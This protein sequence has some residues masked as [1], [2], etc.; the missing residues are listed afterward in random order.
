MSLIPPFFLDAV[1][2]V[3]WPDK[4][5]KP[6]YVATGF[7]FGDLAETKGANSIYR[8]FLVTNRHVFEGKAMAW[9]RFNQE[10][11][12][13]AREFELPLKRPDGTSHWV[14]HPDPEVDLAVA[15]INANF[16]KA[17]AIRF[18]IFESDKH[19]LD[20]KDAID[21]GVSEG[22]GI[23]VLGFP[24]GLVGENRNFVIVRQGAIARIRD[25]MAGKAKTFLADATVFPGNS[26]GPIV[27]RPELVSIQG[28]GALN[29]AYLLGV[30]AGYV[31]YQDIAVSAQTNRPRIIFE[32]NSGLTRAVPVRYLLETVAFAVAKL[33]PSA[34]IEKPVEAIDS[35]NEDKPDGRPEPGNSG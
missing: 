25:A 9:L 33:G 8:V 11:D 28:T 35:K 27:T 5:G 10:G 4:D 2:A 1:V 18:E 30:V 6:S 7:L 23:F 34:P 16:L 21:R 15:M 13:A 17:N 31:P 24:M 3:G 20:T 19:V 14:P 26:G 12:Q 32:E 29:S 22:D